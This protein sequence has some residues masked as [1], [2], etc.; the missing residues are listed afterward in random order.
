MNTGTVVLATD[1]FIKLESRRASL[2]PVEEKKRIFKLL[3][4]FSLHYPQVRFSLLS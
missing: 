1:L 3:C 2:N 4:H